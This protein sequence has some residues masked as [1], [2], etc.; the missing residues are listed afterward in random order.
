ML[1]LADLAPEVRER[2][3]QYAL[4]VVIDGNRE[5]W[6]W[7]PQLSKQPPQITIER[8][9]VDSHGDTLVFAIR[10]KRLADRLIAGE[11]PPIDQD[12]IDFNTSFLVICE[13]VPAQAFFMTTPY[14]QLQFTT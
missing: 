7:A 11:K 2:L 9:C 6:L 12:W 4:D 1:S 10:N 5:R 3:D 13:R 8:L 14:H